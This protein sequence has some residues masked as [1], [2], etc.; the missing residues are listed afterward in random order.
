MALPDSIV[1][2]Q[3]AAFSLSIAL[4][5]PTLRLR[6][7][8]FPLSLRPS[9]M[10]SLLLSSVVVVVVVIASSLFSVL[11]MMPS[12]QTIAFLGLSFSQYKSE[13]G[14]GRRR[15][16]TRKKTASPALFW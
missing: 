5:C 9:C 16:P 11:M 1:D 3:N 4:P 2:C 7:R 13:Q 15:K 12:N 8:L 6:H 10:F 14:P